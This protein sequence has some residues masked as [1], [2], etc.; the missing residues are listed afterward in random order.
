LSRF[1]TSTCPRPTLRP[2]RSLSLA[3]HCFCWYWG[4]WPLLESK[5]DVRSSF[6]SAEVSSLA[7]AINEQVGTLG[8]VEPRYLHLWLPGLTVPDGWADSNVD[9][10]ALTRM[11]ARRIGGGGPW[12]GCEL[13][14]LYRVP[15]VVPTALVLDNAERT[16]RDCGA[17]DIRTHIIE[18]SDRAEVFGVRV[19]GTINMGGRT[20][21]AQYSDYV[22]NTEAGAALVEQAL[23]I[24]SEAISILESE[25]QE[26]TTDVCCA[27]L[28][29]IGRASM[30]G[31]EFQ[32]MRSE[33][34]GFST[35]SHVDEGEQSC[36]LEAA[37]TDSGLRERGTL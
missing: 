19:T 25:V 5:L 23:L 29:S 14:T 34:V 21:C 30:V 7:E 36:T 11:L 32:P 1:L 10:S 33:V 28:D 4:R 20:V 37:P 8:L 27:L 31:H 35:R 24:G 22:V 16:L 2:D 17:A 18:T 26:L 15:G 3:A 12:D 9:G 13:L 6:D